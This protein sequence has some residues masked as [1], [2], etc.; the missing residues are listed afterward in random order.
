MGL[1]IDIFSDSCKL[2]ATFLPTALPD[3]EQGKPYS[4]VIK[5][6][7]GA[8]PGKSSLDVRFFPENSGLNMRSANND[9][10]YNEV[11]IYGTPNIS[12]NIE[13]HFNGTAFSYRGF[14][15]DRTL[16]LK[17]NPVTD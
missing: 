15:F 10:W 17:V 7:G 16:I 8:I 14:V 2:E 4:V 3:A 12:G 11:E 9:D 5:I 6:T 13:I 1:C